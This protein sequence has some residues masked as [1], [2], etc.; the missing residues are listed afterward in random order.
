MDEAYTS[1]ALTGLGAQISNAVEAASSAAPKSEA[2]GLEGI[3]PEG[4]APT[5]RISAKGSQPDVLSKEARRS[6]LNWA[7]TFAVTGLAVG[8]LLTAVI[9]VLDLV[10]K[11]REVSGLWV[12]P[13]FAIVLVGAFGLVI[14]Y[15]AVMG[16]GNV[17]L[18]LNVGDQG[19]GDGGASNDAV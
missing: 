17:E 12:W 8:A 11:D 15:F 10:L 19:G 1:D 6:L 3:Y 9:T 5:G 2:G 13:T 16:Y 14:A 18:G 4:V 7:R